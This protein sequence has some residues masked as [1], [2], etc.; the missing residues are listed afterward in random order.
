MSQYIAGMVK[1]S[2]TTSV[3]TKVS[4]RF[5]NLF[6]KRLSWRLRGEMIESVHIVHFRPQMCVD[7]WFSIARI[8]C[9]AYASIPI[10]RTLLLS[11]C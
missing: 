8:V 2:V 9:N 10:L 4:E 1:R 6:I 5:S 3:G 7:N 11:A